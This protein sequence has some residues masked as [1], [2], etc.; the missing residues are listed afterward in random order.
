MQEGPHLLAPTGTNLSRHHRLGQPFAGYHYDL[1]FIT[2]HGKSRYPGLFAWLRD[3][4]KVPVAVPD[5]CLLLQAGKQ[6]EWLTGGR[7]QAGYHEVVFTEATQRA[8]EG[9]KV[10]GRSQ[11]RVSSTVFSHVA[12][13]RVLQPLGS[14]R[15]QGP[16]V[17]QY[18]P[19]LAGDFVRK[20]LEAISLKKGQKAAV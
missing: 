15:E 14:P 16:E 2:I 6:L 13:D 20:E 5:G 3:G 9:A 11:V 17:H 4:R 1:N 18:P 12:S 10:E 7:I 19:I 8:L